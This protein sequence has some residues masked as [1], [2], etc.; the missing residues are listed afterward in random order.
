[1]Q[2]A[3]QYNP[4]N[5]LLTQQIKSEFNK[6]FKLHIS[7]LADFF[8]WVGQLEDDRIWIA[9]SMLVIVNFLHLVSRTSECSLARVEQVI[10]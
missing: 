2:L 4:H 3:E 9:V 7:S 5:Y 10:Q 1:M 6:Q 8:F